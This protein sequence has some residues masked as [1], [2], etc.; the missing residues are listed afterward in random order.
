MSYSLKKKVVRSKRKRKRNNKSKRL[1]KKNSL[2]GGNRWAEEWKPFGGFCLPSRHHRTA[3]PGACGEGG[4]KKCYN[5]KTH[6]CWKDPE[7]PSTKPKIVRLCV[8]RRTALDGNKY[9]DW[10]EKDK[11]GHPRWNP[12]TH[13]CSDCP[14]TKSDCGEPIVAGGK[15]TRSE[16]KKMSEER[17]RV[18]M[19]S[20]KQ[21]PKEGSD[22]YF[23]IPKT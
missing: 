12:S 9:Y 2:K 20:Q 23:E 16:E 17:E 21:M 7:D 3:L 1:K 22:W 18:Y 14:G 8:R 19:F 10:E 5:K 4:D 11:E 6:Y 13:K 15:E